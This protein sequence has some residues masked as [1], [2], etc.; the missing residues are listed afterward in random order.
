M[1][2]TYSEFLNENSHR[3]Y[4]LRDEVSALDVSGTFVIPSSLIVDMKLCAPVDSIASGTFFISS[5]VIRRYTID[6]GVSYKPD[7]DSAFAVGGFYNIDTTAGTNV[8]YTLV[9]LPQDQI[10]NQLFVDMTGSV[11]I[12]SCEDAITKAGA[13]EFDETT[14]ALN[15]SAISEGLTQVRSIQVGDQRFYG[16]IILKEG[17]NVVLTPVYDAVTDTTTITV[18]AEISGSASDINITSDADIIT[19]LVALYGRPITTIN[20]TEPGEDGNFTLVGA[21]CTNIT[22]GSASVT[23]N[24]PCSDPCCDGTYLDAAYDALNQL[25]VRY[26]RVVDFYDAATRNMDLIQQKLGLLEAQTGYF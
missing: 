21:D 11:V 4:P 3:N 8:T 13:W 18:S 10:D 6:I 12:G 26:A 25:N 1:P 17:D 9:S 22:A 20:N 23:L 14:A 24:N 2:T 19:A 15:A 16:N 5:L 7:A